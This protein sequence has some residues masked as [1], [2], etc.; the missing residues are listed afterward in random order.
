VRPAPYD[1]GAR[2]AAADVDKDDQQE[3]LVY[4]PEEAEEPF[5]QGHQ[6]YAY[7][8]TNKLVSDVHFNNPFNPLPG[9][10]PGG[11]IAATDRWTRN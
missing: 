9:A 6:V 8:P 11:A 3:I 5:D 1:G 10:L 7:E 4:I 2:V